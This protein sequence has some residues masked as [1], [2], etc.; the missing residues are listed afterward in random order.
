MPSDLEVDAAALRGCAQAVVDT[1]RQVSA[2]TEPPPAPATPRWATTGEAAA[3]AEAIR[4]LLTAF[5]ADLDADARALLSA[6]EDY[7]AA[8]RRAAAR[9]GAAG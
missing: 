6:A 1:A 9:L 2:G 7:E 8:D 5:D 3:L 4:G